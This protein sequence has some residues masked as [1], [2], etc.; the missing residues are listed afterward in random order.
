M[1]KTPPLGVRAKGKALYW[2]PYQVGLIVS[3]RGTAVKVIYM[4]PVCGSVYSHA[5]SWKYH[6]RTKHPDFMKKME[7]AA[8]EA[9]EAH[10][11]K[12]MLSALLEDYSE[13]WGE[14]E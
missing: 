9:L 12:I 3:T 5:R 13:D 8:Y 10:R 2:G 4:C 7:E 11:K 1:E 14:E 6:L